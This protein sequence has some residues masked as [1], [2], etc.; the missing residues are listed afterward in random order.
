MMLQREGKKEVQ[1]R[2]SNTWKV[3]RS[4]PLEV[5]LE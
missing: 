2:G 5:R 4:Q 3:Q 1:A